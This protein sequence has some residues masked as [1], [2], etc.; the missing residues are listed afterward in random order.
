[1]ITLPED[2][3]QQIPATHGSGGVLLDRQRLER[4][5]LLPAHSGYAFEYK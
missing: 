2:F 5:L 4:G 3:G 1:M